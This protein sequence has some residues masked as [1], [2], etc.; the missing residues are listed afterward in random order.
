MANEHAPSEKRLALQRVYVKRLSFASKK[1]PEAFTSHA[2]PET[3]L[4]IRSVNRELDP[5]HVD[6]ELTVRVKSVA[7]EDTVFLI[8]LV[9][10]G[11]FAMRGYSPEERFALLGSLCPSMLYPYAR[12]A[13]TDIANKG[14]FPQLLVQPLDF[15]AMYAQNMWERPASSP[16]AG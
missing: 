5:E 16:Q 2:A 11:I 3:F 9:Q 12:E 15:N 7:Q 8:E 10:A 6:V 14:G 4:N 1:V 13:I